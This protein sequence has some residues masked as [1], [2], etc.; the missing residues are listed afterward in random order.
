MKTIRRPSGVHIGSPSMP[1]LKVNRLDAVPR[2]IPDPDLGVPAIEDAHHHVRSVGR[3]RG[4]RSA[5]GGASSD[6]SRPLRSTHTSDADRRRLDC[7][8]RNIDECAPPR[9][10]VVG[11]TAHFHHHAF[12]DGHRVPE[13]G[14]P[15]GSNRTALASQP[16]RR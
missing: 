1:G 13:H 3:Q 5:P 4:G 2:K 11:C 8:V 9:D 16:P 14:E 12:D 10:G 15:L 7:A 6:S